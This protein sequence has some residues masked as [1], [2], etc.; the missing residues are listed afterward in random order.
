MEKIF[1]AEYANM[2]TENGYQELLEEIKE[3]SK[4]NPD[5]TKLKLNLDGRNPDDGM[6]S[7]AYEKGRFLLTR[8]EY[9]VGRERWDSF[10]NMYFKDNAFKT[11]NTT[12]F[13]EYINTNLFN[14]NPEWAK[15]VNLEKWIYEPGLPANCPVISSTLLDLVRNEMK[16]FELEEDVSKINAENWTTHQWLYFL[17]NSNKIVIQRNISELDNRFQFTNS[18]NSEILCDWFKHGIECNYKGNDFDSNL[19]SFLMRVGRRKFLDPL[20]TRLA[21][22]NKDWA[23]KVFTNAKNGYHSV[24]SN[25]IEEI[26]K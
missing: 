17:R 8:I 20:Y 19:E 9:T 3:I 16:I 26:L 23:I 2:E 22:H 12:K 5:D 25:T 10:L 4:E 7:I 24:A 1:G 13:I 15:I 14:E 21:V 6:T 18:T 11:M